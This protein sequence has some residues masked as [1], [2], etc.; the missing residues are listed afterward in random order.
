MNEE[1]VAIAK[2]YAALFQVIY[3]NLS[4]FKLWSKINV[5]ILSSLRPYL[6]KELQNIIT[7]YINLCLLGKGRNVEGFIRYF[8]VKKP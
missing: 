5:N 4:S 1:F 2:K 3:N 6:K 7:M 8:I